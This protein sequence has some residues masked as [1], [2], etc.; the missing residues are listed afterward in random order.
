MDDRYKDDGGSSPALSIIVPFYK[1]EKYACGCI[2]SI[3]S[4]SFTDFELARSVTV[5]RLKM[6]V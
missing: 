6:S 2:E 1:V 4:Q 3:L 5:M